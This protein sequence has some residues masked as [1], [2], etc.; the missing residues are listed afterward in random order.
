VTDTGVMCRLKE[1]LGKLS[2]HY[3][4]GKIPFGIATLK[5]LVVGAETDALPR[6]MSFFNDDEHDMIEEGIGTV[7][8]FDEPVS[9]VDNSAYLAKDIEQLLSW[10][11]SLAS[12]CPYPKV[13]KDLRRLKTMEPDALGNFVGKH[14]GVA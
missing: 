6:V 12:K 1:P 9:E 14:L 3:S 13:A 10:A 8:S 7:M 4:W 5:L 2:G 11:P